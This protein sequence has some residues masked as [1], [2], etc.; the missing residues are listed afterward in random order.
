MISTDAQLISDTI[1]FVLQGFIAPI[2]II[3]TT[4]LLW[5]VCALLLNLNTRLA[6]HLF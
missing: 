4:G 5:Q 6:L 3:I 1:V 2:Q